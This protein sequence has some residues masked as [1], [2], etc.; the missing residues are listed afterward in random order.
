MTQVPLAPSFKIA[1][2]SSLCIC[3]AQLLEFSFFSNS[4]ATVSTVYIL[5]IGMCESAV[6]IVLLNWFGYFF[7]NLPRLSAFLS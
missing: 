5:L 7:K 6:C 3:L 2:L 4:T 1:V